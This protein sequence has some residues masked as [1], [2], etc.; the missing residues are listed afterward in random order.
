MSSSDYFP[1]G[2]TETKSKKTVFDEDGEVSFAKNTTKPATKTTTTPKVRFIVSKS[3]EHY[4]QHLLN[5]KIACID[6]AK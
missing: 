1:R 2:G 6:E 3:Y 5:M 4:C